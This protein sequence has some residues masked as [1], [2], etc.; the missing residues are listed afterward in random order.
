M[1]HLL[2]WVCARAKSL[3]KRRNLWKNSMC[4]SWERITP[5]AAWV[6]HGVELRAFIARKMPKSMH[7]TRPYIGKELR[8]LPQK[9]ISLNYKMNLIF[10]PSGVTKGAPYPVLTSH[11]T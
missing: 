2:S 4:H 1:F 7:N 3:R 9:D 5:F 8:Q 10:I 11:Q 6:T